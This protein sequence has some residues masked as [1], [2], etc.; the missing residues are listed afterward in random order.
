[1]DSDTGGKSKHDFSDIMSI[2]GEEN[3]P[4]PGGEK[5]PVPVITIK[6]EPVN[7][8]DNPFVKKLLLDIEHKNAE[9]LKL[10]SDNMSLKY[11]LSE[12]EME[13]K[14]LQGQSASLGGQVESLKS[15]VR[16][17]NRQIEDMNKYVSD[18]RAKLG[19]MDADRAKLTA[20]IVKEEERAPPD[21]ED[22]IASIF[23][24]IALKGEEPSNGAPGDGEDKPRPPKKAGTAKLYDL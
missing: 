7:P 2:L 17:L 13:I 10:N 15:Q 12:K 1:M 18:A 20:R 23:K 19:E 21:D 4:V 16:E 24:R 11:A 5:K 6:P 22:D 9:I 8:R 14:R 3:T